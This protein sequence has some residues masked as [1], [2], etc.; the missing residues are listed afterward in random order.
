[1]PGSMPGLGAGI[2]EQ[3]PPRGHRAPA[4]GRKGLQ[5]TTKERCTLGRVSDRQAQG[6]GEA[7]AGEEA[8][9]STKTSWGKSPARRGC[10]GEAGRGERRVGRSQLAQDP[11]AWVKQG[12]DGIRFEA[13]TLLSGSILENG[14]GGAGWTPRPLPPPTDGADPELLRARVRWGPEVTFRFDQNGGTAGRRR[15]SS[16]R[17]A[18]G[19]SLLRRATQVCTD[20]A[21][22]SS[23]GR[24]PRPRP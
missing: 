5:L 4:R 18:H 20:V 14:S 10:V 23:R 15:G 13:Q 24:K 9:G 22:H 19:S 1:M 17:M 8:R 7:S 11:E 3:A 6:P 2:Q 12:T 21:P 16:G